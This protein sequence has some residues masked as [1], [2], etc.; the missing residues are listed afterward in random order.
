[1]TGRDEWKMLDRGWLV[2]RGGDM[3]DATLTRAA[4]LAFNSPHL[5]G[6]W[7]ISVASV[8]E[9][10]AEEIVRQCPNIT[11]KRYRVAQAGDL[12]DAGFLPFA[13]NPPHAVLAF[14]EPPTLETWST[15]RSIFSGVFVNPCYSERKIYGGRK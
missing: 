11:Q 4:E 10:S 1:M 13:D 2:V 14:Q 7:A 6:T 15:L 12:I 3:A 5:R 8:P 9:V